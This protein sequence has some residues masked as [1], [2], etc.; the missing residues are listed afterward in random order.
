M[1]CLCDQL[2]VTAPGFA[3][4][5]QIIDATHERGVPANLDG[6]DWLG[7]QLSKDMC[8]TIFFEVSCCSRS[9]IHDIPMAAGQH[10]YSPTV[11]ITSE[12]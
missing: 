2:T 9:F 10:T 1:P 11:N 8:A 7:A 3:P 4:V 6:D 5:K 12:P